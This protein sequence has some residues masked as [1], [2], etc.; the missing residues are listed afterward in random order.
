MLFRSV[1]V[2]EG[3][4]SGKYVGA[5]TFK[6]TLFK[7]GVNIGESTV[8]AMPTTIINFAAIINALPGGDVKNLSG[9]RV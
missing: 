3:T 7:N 9:Y 2:N 1:I 8:A 6:A 4:P 5:I